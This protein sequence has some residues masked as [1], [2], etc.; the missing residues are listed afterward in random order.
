MRGSEHTATTVLSR[1][2]VA[3]LAGCGDDST[4]TAEPSATRRP[5]SRRPPPAQTTPR[6]KPTPA[7]PKPKPKPRT[8]VIVVDQGRPRAGSSGPRSSRASR[9]CSSSAPTRATRCTCTATTSRSRSRRASRCAIPLTANAPGPLRGRAPPSRRAARGARGPALTTR[10]ARDRRRSR[11]CRSPRGSSTGARRSCSSSRSSLLGAL[12]QRP[13]LAR[14]RSRA[15]PARSGCRG[16]CS[17]R[18]AS[19]VQAL[20]VALFVLV[21]AAALARRHRPVPE[22]RADLGLRRL[23]ARPAVAL[24]RSSANVWR[25]LIAVARA[26]GR[27]RLAARAR[28]ARGEA[29]R[30]L[31]GAPRPLAGRGRALRVR[32]ARARLRGP[33]Q[34]ARARVR[35]RALHVRRRSSAWRRSAA[36]RGSAHGEGFAVLFGFFARMAPLTARDGRLRVRWPFTGLAGAEP[37]PGS[38]AFIAVMLGSVGFD[39]F[40]RTTTV[41]EPAR[42]RRRRRS[43]STGPALGEL[44]VTL[45]EPRR[46][47]RRFAARRRGVR[48]GCAVARCGRQR[49]ARR[50]AGVPAQPRPDRVRLRRRALLLALRHP[51]PVRDAAPLRPV[52]QG[53][54]PLR[55]GRLRAEPG[56]VTPNDD[57]VRP[58]RRARRRP[59]R[60]PR[61]RARPRGDDLPRPRDGAALAVRDARAD[62]ALHGRRA[63]DALARL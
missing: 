35:D 8:I 51:G 16:S 41:A 62:G 53:L 5:P 25:A 60:R 31:P 13:L 38:L 1:R 57:L 10:R 20:S 11:T 3:L 19:R 54:G 49:A 28:R 37:V 47:A 50:S 30:R 45:V 15:R 55:H 26:R 17:A 6:P 44:L 9:S 40:S 32:R 36:R 59:R 22:P 4:S 42:R 39:G 48:G 58:G 18:S 63:L 43:S 7:K 2:A 52:R 23:L 24:G 61:G 33:F 56:A 34:P 29:A 21:W 27:L 46:A 12:W 14:A